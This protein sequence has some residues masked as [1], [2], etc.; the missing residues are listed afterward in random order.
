ML[1][2]I[3]DVEFLVNRCDEHID[4]E[5]RQFLLDAGCNAAVPAGLTTDQRGPG[6]FRIRGAAVD[7]GAFETGN[8]LPPQAVFVPAL[9]HDALGRAASASELNLWAAFYTT[10]F[11]AALGAGAT[12]AQA[13]FQAQ[14]AVA[15]D[16]EH[17][18]EARDHLVRGWCAT[19]LGREAQGGEE[20]GWV[21][22][23]LAG[24]SEEQVLSGILATPEF[25]GHAQTL[26]D[27]G[28]ADQNFIQALYRLL[29]GRTGSDTETAGQIGVL[30][31]LG[32]QGVAVRFLVSTEH[33]TDLVQSYYALLL[34]RPAD[35]Q[36][37]NGWVFSGLGELGVR[38]GIEAS[39]E[40]FT[41]G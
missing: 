19:F 4:A 22:Q 30:P 9:Y 6:F 37:L 16:I 2:V 11:N 5:F 10:E 40:F 29:L 23:L 3:Q 28:T 12:A 13:Q 27:S 7:L 31:E 25:Y 8:P 38:V 14:A 41:D 17:G 36:D 32:R 20:Q 18:P 33:R 26:G 1:K 21:N 39:P 35:P 24:T 34:H 15:S